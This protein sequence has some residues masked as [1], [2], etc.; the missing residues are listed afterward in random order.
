MAT[1][2]V[3][4][5]VVRNLPDLPLVASAEWVRL[6]QDLVLMDDVLTLDRPAVFLA[7][8]DRPVLFGAVAWADVLL[9]HDRGDFGELLGGDFYGLRVLTP[10]LFLKRERSTG[11]LKS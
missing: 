1:P 4:E 8:K 6:R 11:R 2:Y 7:G 9:T 5:E 3:V 10:G